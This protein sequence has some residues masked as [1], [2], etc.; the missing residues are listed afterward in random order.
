MTSNDCERLHILRN[1]YSGTHDRTMAE[2]VMGI[3]K[4]E[5]HRNQAVLADNGGH[6]KGLD[7]L[8]IATCAW[9]SWFNE[10]RLHSELGDRTP[11][12]LEAEYRDLDQAKVA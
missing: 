6:W 8:E 9:V 10:E 4:T 3:F 7:D 1:D 5:L 12:E 2:S 11:L